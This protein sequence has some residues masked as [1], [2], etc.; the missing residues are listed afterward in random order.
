MK[1]N[2]HE[3][4][5]ATGMD[6]APKPGDIVQWVE[7]GVQWVVDE[8][9]DLAGPSALRHWPDGGWCNVLLVSRAGQTV[10]AKGK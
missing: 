8:A 2:N 1:Y 9:D 4:I 6:P 5:T 10:P 7:N 3:D